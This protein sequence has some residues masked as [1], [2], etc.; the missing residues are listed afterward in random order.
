MERKRILWSNI[1][2]WL[3]IHNVCNNVITKRIFARVLHIDMKS[4]NSLNIRNRCVNVLTSNY[5]YK[6]QL[7]GDNI[8]KDLRNR[9]LFSVYEQT[10]MSPLK[11]QK[12]I[13]LTIMMPIL[14][15]PAKNEE[16]ACYI[17]NKLKEVGHEAVFSVNDY[18]LLMDGLKI[19]KS[20]DGGRKISEKF[21]KFLQEQKGAII[22]VGIVHGDFH[23]DNIMCKDNMPVLIDFDCSRNNDI[24]AID[25][26]YYILHHFTTY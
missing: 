3:R 9:K 21:Y 16:A 19:L 22:R 8:R 17:L 13:P 15:P 6:I 10:L 11:I 2:N 25:A 14:R 23:R 1:D 18:P 4:I 20:C 7:Y 26:L 12:R 5:L 24:Q